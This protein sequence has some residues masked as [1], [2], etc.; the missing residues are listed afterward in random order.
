MS[1]KL[2]IVMAQLDFLVGDIQGNLQKHIQAAQEARDIMKADVIVFSELSM[3]GYPPEDLLNRAAFI[4]E[5][6]EAVNTFKSTV[7]GIHC[8]VGHPLSSSKGLYN[9]C[10]LIYNN[11]ILARSNKKFLPN[12]G[13]FDEHRYF[14]SGEPHGIALIHDIPVAI[15]ICEDLWYAAPVQ[16]AAAQGARIIL[17]PNASPFEI[18]KDAQRQQVVAKRARANNVPIVYVNQVGAQDDLIFDGGSMVIDA[19]GTVCQQM[20]FFKSALLPVDIE[21]SSV[22]SQVAKAPFNTPA[23]TEKIYQALVMSVRD[24]VTK[25]NFTG[26]LIGVSG[27]IDSA[28][29]LAIAVDALG[30]ENVKA[31]VMPSRF[32]AP[33]SLTDAALLIKNFGVAHEDISIEPVFIS[34]LATLAPVFGDNKPDITE[35]NIQSRCRGVILMALSNKSGRIV[36]TTGNRS[37]MAVGYATLYGDMAGGFAVLKDIPK[38]MVYE[39]A[40]YRNKAGEMIP[41]NILAR[42]PTAELAF[43]QKDEDSLPPYPVLD[44]ILMLYLNEEQSVEQIIAQGM[45]RTIVEKVV[46]LIHK[47]EYKRKQSPIGPRIN[48][49]AFGRDRRYPVTS[50]YKT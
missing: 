2:R 34:F 9:S 29:V 8:V 23:Q 36:L 43:D 12:Y 11:T 19:T 33:V 3:T 1:K 40:K 21:I 42:A 5:S 48:H 31:V 15:I 28:L 30:K 22:E 35:E 41:Q 49:T 7:T 26:A 10:S 20:E 44:K 24:Y 32:T 4:D 37:E 16:A 25:N 27:G 39:L 17:S 14:I 13:V 38:M 6:N 45:D 46:G 47:N 50:G 18:D